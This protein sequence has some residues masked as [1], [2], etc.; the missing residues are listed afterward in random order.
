MPLNEVVLSQ[1][2]AARKE[3]L[4]IEVQEGAASVTASRLVDLDWKL[5]VTQIPCQLCAVLCG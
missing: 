5:N 1:V 3:D 2:Y 4:D